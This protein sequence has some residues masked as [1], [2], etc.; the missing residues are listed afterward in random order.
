[1]KCVIKFLLLI[2]LFITVASEDFQDNP[3][4]EKAFQEFYDQ[5][6]DDKEEKKPIVYDLKKSKELFT[7]YIK[8]FNKKYD[9]YEDYKTHYKNFVENL[10]YINSVNSGGRSFSTDINLFSDMKAED[11]G[12]SNERK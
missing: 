6:D 12:G 2:T 5:Y 8:D 7:K 1:M 4:D 11:I 10:K 3:E 9:T